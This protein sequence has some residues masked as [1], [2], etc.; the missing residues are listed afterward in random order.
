MKVIGGG[1]VLGCVE[2]VGDLVKGAVRRKL[3]WITN[4]RSLA[5]SLR[6]AR[7]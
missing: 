7:A 3:A 4:T 6:N 5:L 2:D 1:Y